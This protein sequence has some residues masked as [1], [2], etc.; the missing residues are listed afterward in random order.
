VAGEAL[1]RYTLAAK[2]GEPPLPRSDL[3]RE[4]TRNIQREILEVAFPRT[5]AVLGADGLEA[6]MSRFLE[7]GGPETLQYPCVPDDLVAWARALE[8][9]YWDLLDF[10]RSSV[11]A[12]RH[13][14]EIDLLRV[15]QRGE[16][17]ALNPTLQVSSYTRLVHE[18]T[19]ENSDPEASASP[20][21][22]LAWRKPQSD[23]VARQRVGIVVGRCLGL[24]GMAPITKEEWVEQALS[25]ETDHD[26]ISLPK[27]LL[28]TYED[29]IGR[30]GIVAAS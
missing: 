11:R 23:E 29:L 1:V 19:V 5:R 21:V 28:E 20:P 22:Y 7:D 24:L 27:V 30:A 8:H 2:P 15:P 25:R 9:P 12:E 13:P 26:P 18:I 17:L 3:Y 6:L 10:E 14:A 16:R 4:L